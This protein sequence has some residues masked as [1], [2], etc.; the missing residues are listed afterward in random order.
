MNLSTTNDSVNVDNSNILFS[1]EIKPENMKINIIEKDKKIFDFMQ[2]EK[3]YINIINE[4]KST[5]EKKDI[6]I[7]ELNQEKKELEYTLGKKDNI[8]KQNDKSNIIEIDELK[9]KIMNYQNEIENLKRK[10]MNKENIIK[11]YEESKRETYEQHNQKNK[12]IVELINQ[13]KKN[14]TLLKN[15]KKKENELK[16]ENKKIPIL[17]RKITDLEYVINQNKIEINE[18][19]KNNKNMENEKEN[20]NEMIDIKTNEIQKGKVSE[21]YVIRLN[22]KIDYL[23]KELKNIGIENEILNNQNIALNNDINYFFNIISKE[24]NNFLNFLESLNIYSKSLHKMPSSILPNFQDTK[25][26][27]KYTI[28]YDN[29]SSII[30]KI[31]EKILEILN[32]N[33]EKNQDIFIDSIS[34]DNNYKELL[35]EKDEL[36]KNKIEL[37]NNIICANPFN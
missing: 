20:L 32:K 19:K 28:K 14:E 10:I 11:S 5:L 21:Q 23:S 13:I 2:Q 15:M 9:N 27:D 30:T 25:K 8:I 3:E 1:K 35:N 12:E 26:S 17:K 6:E 31:E 16:E 4:L 36:N 22:Y 37:E 7:S 24:L 18:L 33:I 34:K 29:L